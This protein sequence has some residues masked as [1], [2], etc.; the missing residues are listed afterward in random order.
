MAKVKVT[1][2]PVKKGSGTVIAR[3]KAK[4][5]VTDG[6]KGKAIY[7]TEARVF[8]SPKTNQHGDKR[9]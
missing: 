4:V 9:D 8:V 3:G 5:K 1:V 2:K 6:A 7:Q